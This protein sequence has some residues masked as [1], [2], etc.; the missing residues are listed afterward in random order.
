MGFFPKYTR[1]LTN[2]ILNLNFS[3]LCF[4]IE[5]LFTFIDTIIILLRFY[6]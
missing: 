5:K 4:A 6:R 2:F 3:T 1:L